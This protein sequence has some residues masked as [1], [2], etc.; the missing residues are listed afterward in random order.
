MQIS[1]SHDYDG[2]PISLYEIDQWIDD[3]ETIVIIHPT[4]QKTAFLTDIVFSDDN[5]IVTR[6][7]W[8]YDYGLFL[9]PETEDGCPDL[10]DSHWLGVNYVY[11]TNDK[12]FIHS[13]IVEICKQDTQQ[14]PF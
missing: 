6:D 12:H 10:D 14:M 9:I 1:Y 7:G 4:G 13:V 2:N 3:G 5:S 8:G 11:P